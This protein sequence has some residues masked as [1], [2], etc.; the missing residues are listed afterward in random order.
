MQAAIEARGEEAE[1]DDDDDDDGGATAG[2]PLLPHSTRARRACAE[3]LRALRCLVFSEWV[4]PPPV[5]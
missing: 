2:A 3:V 1:S 4:W 5:S